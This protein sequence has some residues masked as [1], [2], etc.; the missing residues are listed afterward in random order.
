MSFVVRVVGVEGEVGN[1]GFGTA[2]G[3]TL[4]FGL[5]LGPGLTPHSARSRAA[6]RTSNARNGDRRPSTTKYAVPSLTLASRASTVDRATQDACAGCAGVSLLW[7]CFASSWV[8][9]AS[10]CWLP[11]ESMPNTA[12]SAACIAACC[13]RAC[14]STRH[15][16]GGLTALEKWTSSEMEST[17]A[18]DRN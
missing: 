10:T 3:V 13:V 7:R 1:L 12:S 2:F 18:I 4:T 8:A 6:R 15:R 5:G 14:P 16:Y 11:P 9:S 17:S